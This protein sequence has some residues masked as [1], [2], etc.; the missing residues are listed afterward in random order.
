MGLG[1]VQYTYPDTNMEE[2]GFRRILK[3]EQKAMQ[4]KNKSSN[5]LLNDTAQILQ[6]LGMIILVVIT[7]QAL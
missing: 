1:I 5:G 4:D 3:A 6:V 2:A 7:S